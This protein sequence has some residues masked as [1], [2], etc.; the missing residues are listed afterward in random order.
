MLYFI[1]FSLINPKAIFVGG[2]PDGIPS[3]RQ[4]DITVTKLFTESKVQM[5]QI[6][7]HSREIESP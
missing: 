6:T 2:M 3:P 7:D 5:Q 1:S 4:L